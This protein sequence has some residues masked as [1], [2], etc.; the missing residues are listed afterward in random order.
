MSWALHF[1]YGGALVQKGQISTGDGFKTFF[2]LVGTGKVIAKAGSMTSDLAEGST[3]IATVLKIL[4]RQSLIPG[5]S[6]AGDGTS[7]S[8]LQ[9]IFGNIEM[10]KVDFAYRSWPE[11][12][13]STIQHGSEAKC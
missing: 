13:V 12:L 10:R 8:K 11:T 9:K 3:A 6:Q 4:E 5:S 7:G 1:W 2:I